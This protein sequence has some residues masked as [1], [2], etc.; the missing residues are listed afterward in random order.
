[1]THPGI[2]RFVKRNRTVPMRAKLLECPSTYLPPD[3]GVMAL[4][5][6]QRLLVGS[7]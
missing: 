2:N 4:P 1:V 6:A 3:K 5:F 7:G